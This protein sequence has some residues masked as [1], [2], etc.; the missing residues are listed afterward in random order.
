M[1]VKCNACLRSATDRFSSHK[2]SRL[3][4]RPLPGGAWTLT[5]TAPAAL[6][7]AF[8]LAACSPAFNWREIRP[9]NSGLSLL[10]PC[11]PEKA[12]KMVPLGGPPTN[13]ILL[14]CDTGG[15]TFAVAMADISDASKVPT[16]LEQWQNLTLAN[17][18]APLIPVAAASATAAQAVQA[19]QGT[20]LTQR[21]LI[22]VPGANLLSPPVLVKARGQRPGGGGV[23]GH[24]AYFS[25]GTQVFQVVLYADKVQPEESETFF[26]SLKFD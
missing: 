3:M 24:A 7:V 15:A 18:N 23:T 4:S 26:S 10:F 21:A 17:M 25:R 8:A 2:V 20:L 5:A 12:E 16:V 14:G 22:K 13:L 6:F 9:D 19:V 1:P 11:K